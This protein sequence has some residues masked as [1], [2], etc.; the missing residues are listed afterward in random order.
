MD[1]P[2]LQDGESGMANWIRQFKWFY[3]EALPAAQRTQALSEV[4]EKLAPVL[5]NKD[6]WFAH[7]R[8]LRVVAVKV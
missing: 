7:Y 5:R 4:L 8:R 2:T 6:G 3:F 1:R